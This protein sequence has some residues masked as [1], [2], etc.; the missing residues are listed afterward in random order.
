MRPRRT[1]QPIR[2]TRRNRRDRTVTCLPLER[3]GEVT[4]CWPAMDGQP[5]TAR[6]QV[7]FDACFGDLIDR[8]LTEP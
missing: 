8:I 2:T 6:E 7:L 1:D 4:L 5:V 3:H